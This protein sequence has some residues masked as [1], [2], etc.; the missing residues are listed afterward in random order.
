MAKIYLDIDD[1][2]KD[3]PDLYLVAHVDKDDTMRDDYIACIRICPMWRQLYNA[4][5]GKK[6]V[7]KDNGFLYKKNEKGEWRLV[8]PSTFHMNGK[9]YLE[10]AINEPYNATAHGGVEKT[11]KCFTDKCIC[12]PFSRLIKE[13]VASC[14]TCQRMK[15]SNKPPL[16]QVTILYV[17]ARAWTD[18]TM[19]F[20]KISP[21]FTYC[22]TLYTD[23]PLEDDHMICFSRLWAIVCRQS[24]FMFLISVLDNLTAE[25]CTDTFDMH[26][27]SVIGYPYYIVFDRDTLFM[28]DHFQDWA[29]RKRIKLELSTAYHPQTDG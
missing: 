23:I 15:Y 5:E 16:G 24:G 11:L 25:K 2:P 18:I 22:S 17:P 28:S 27:A 3:D 8:L 19:N 9:N 12:Q 29:A 14:D 13:Y 4:L 20:L 1:G 21:V 26:V 6:G 10:D 7:S